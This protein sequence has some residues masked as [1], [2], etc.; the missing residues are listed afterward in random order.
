MSKL[1]HSNQETMDEIERR[2]AIENG[3]ED[4]IEQ[5]IKA[6][7]VEALENLLT[8][9]RVERPAFRAKPVGAP[10]S[11]ERIKQ[12]KLIAL[13]DAARAALSRATPT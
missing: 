12:D 1:A 5:S 10:N 6:D 9:D 7:L 13:E 4:L 11:S 2:A 8:Y 3:N